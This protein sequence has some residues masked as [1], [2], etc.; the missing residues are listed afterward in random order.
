M[1]PA[2][3][4]AYFVEQLPDR[5]EFAKSLTKEL[6]PDIPDDPLLCIYNQIEGDDEMVVE[7]TEGV[8]TAYKR[9]DKKV[10][11]VPGQ[12]PEEIRVTRKFPEDPLRSLPT[13][14]IH[15][16]IFQPTSHLTTERLEEM[17][18][19]TDQFLWPEEEKLFKHIL[20]LNEKTLVF[21]ENDRGTLREDYFSPYIIPTIPHIPWA[22]SHIPIP[23]GLRDKVIELLKEKK[24]AG[25][26]EQSQSSYRSRWFCVLKK[27]GKLRIVHDLQPLNAVTIRD[28]GL[29]P[30]LDAFVEPFAGRQ[31]YTAFD[32]HWGFDARK[33]HPISRDLTAFMSPL[34]LMRLTSLPM[35][36]TNS[37]AEFQA[38]MAFI[39][40]DEMPDV[41]D[42]FIDDLPIKGP[43]TIYPDDNGNPEVLKENPGIRR[44][45]WEHAQDVHRIMHRIGHAG[46]T[47][48]PSKIQLARREAIILGHKCTPEGR[49]PDPLTIDKVKNWPTLKTPKNVREFLGL[50]GT[51]RIWIKNYSTRA[52]PLTELIRH[53]VEFK[54]D[55]RRQAAFEDLKD[56]ITSPPVLQPIDYRSDRPIVLSVDTSQTA[57]G[58][59]LSQ[60]DE[61]GKKHPARYGSIPMNEREARYSQPKLELY[62]LFRALR[63]FRLYLVGAKKLEI[64]VDAKY[65]KGMLKEP[66]LQPNASIN[67]WIQGILLFDFELIHTP[68]E[69][70]KGPDALSRKELGEGEVIEDEDDTWLDNIALYTSVPHPTTAKVKEPIPSYLATEKAQDQTMKAIREYLITRHCPPTLTRTEQVRIVTQSKRFLLRRGELYKRNGFKPPVKAIFSAEQR[71]HILKSAHEGLG[72]RGE[73]ALM[74][75]LKERFYWPNMWKDAQSHVKSCYECQ[76]RSTKKAETP[77][78]ISIPIT[79]FTKIHVDLMYMDKAMG[80]QFVVA[81]RDDLSRASEGR[82]LRNTKAKTL[83]QFFWEDII[84]RYGAI[85]QVVTDNGPEVS[86][87][88]SELTRR[89]GIPHIKISPYNSK[90]NGVVERGHFIIRESIMKACQ[91]HPKRWPE[92]VHHAFFADKV[93]VTRSTGMSPYYLLH[94]VHP[95]LPFDL[96][97]MTI[98]SEGYNSGMTTAELLAMRIRQLEKRQSDL[99]QAAQLLTETRMKSKE[100]FERRY[101]RRLRLSEY[102]PGTLVLVRNTQVEKSLNRKS[103]PR[104]LGPFQVV[105]VTQNNSYIVQELDGSIWRQKIA[106]FR[107]IPFI[108][109]KELQFSELLQKSQQTAHNA[110][111]LNE[112][113]TEEEM[114]KPEKSG[115]SQSIKPQRRQIP[116][117][118]INRD[119][120]S[121]V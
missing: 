18:I 38:C 111:I 97:E 42:I 57:V 92:Y 96:T 87:E 76:I 53:N 3:P 40:Q 33:I 36:F 17:K 51:A 14:P 55:E 30:I 108:Q 101:Q 34:G 104:Y 106:A 120:K 94:G 41:A 60:R 72:H 10:K 58:F 1:P 4:R 21:E 44:F 113:S 73:Y 45:I 78:T 63:A 2:A 66:D 19:N 114:S 8:Y 80:Y 99:D 81:A 121:V 116:E 98:L 52:R 22:F 100:Q 85:G 46:G 86:E 43:K 107:I 91:Q 37:P 9:V 49:V 15:P 31:C 28:A 12:I 20:K 90:A 83:S 75:T 105:R 79:L 95:V 84:C 24:E 11:P 39:L 69:Q 67:R 29:P 23:P 61:Q 5:Q 56:A 77:L 82:A 88:F 35:G 59:I 93:T 68:A 64:E 118:V 119:R 7:M 89:Y 65:I 70:H 26:Y 27:N 103:K 25:V 13:L 102:K 16:P 71:N 47:F 117:V 48:S 62:G 6:Y 54:W 74:Q 50:C 32:L 115:A 109:R 112:E 110:K